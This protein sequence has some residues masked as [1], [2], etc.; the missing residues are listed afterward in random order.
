MS[1]IIHLLPDSIANQI[2]AGE[3]IQRPS[4]MLKELVENSIDAHATQIT[5]ELQDAGKELMRVIDN[6]VG[7]SPL[8]AR[9]AFERHATSKI[10]SVDDLFTLRSMGFRGEALASIVAV[11]QIELIT[12]QADSE[13]GH[14]LLIN[15]SE[16]IYS[17]PT[18]AE[19]GTSITV[20]NLFYNVPARRR[21]LKAS[22]TELK[23]IYRQF[24]RIALVYPEVSFTLYSEGKIVRTLP[25][26]D[27][28]HR[29][30]DLLGKS[31][32][33]QLIPIAYQGPLANISG[34]ITLPRDAKRR[35]AQQFFFVNGRY[36]KHAYFH[37]AVMN[38][39]ED[40]VAPNSQPNYFIYFQV[41][42]SR[43]DVNIHP[44]KTE[45][46]FLDEQAIF[47]L[48]MVVLREHLSTTSAMPAITFQKDQL[49]S[50]PAYDARARECALTP[51]P[52]QIDPSYNP[53][54]TVSSKLVDPLDTFRSSASDGWAGF[55]E[56]FQQRP[57]ADSSPLTTSATPDTL[58]AVSSETS[59]PVDG[60]NLV[61]TFQERYLFTAMSD[62]LA[63]ISIERALLRIYYEQ[64]IATLQLEP[65]QA[66]PLLFAEEL[67]LPPEVYPTSQQ[68]IASLRLIG[69]EISA[70]ECETQRPG[71]DSSYPHGELCK[72]T[73]DPIYSIYAVPKPLRPIGIADL[74]TEILNKYL[75]REELEKNA[76]DLTQAEILAQLF[77]S[78]EALRRASDLVRNTLH[79]RAAQPSQIIS[80][81]FLTPDSQF[82][83]LGRSI[84]I[85]LSSD[86]IAKWF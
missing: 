3:V 51:P 65:E 80:D 79:T 16:V 30:V 20:K 33:K 68:L 60:A 13:I 86:E 75:T 27:L 62:R 35:G 72:D 41:D 50:I 76:P 28:Q 59:Q 12:R 84:M 58:F 54:N 2:A 66:Q 37:R 42:P 32:A 73:V 7:M 82:D 71:E 6:G 36:M 47:K 17:A 24:E 61:Y 23:H 83:P 46:K 1:E 81:L 34:F 19:V 78:D 15:G 43:I 26:S 85:S 40:L 11:A 52:V 4:S 21:F 8:D 25:K 45:I 39:F 69:F 56:D 38:V 70:Q 5:I 31:Y 14:K 55:I 63:V 57:G 29:I 77:L 18:M 9:M 44:T 10:S 67:S 49:I 22:D 48:L 74:V 64:Q 53:F